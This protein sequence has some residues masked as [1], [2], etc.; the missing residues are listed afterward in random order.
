MAVF[1][2]GATGRKADLSFPKC[3]LAL[4]RTFGEV[5]CRGT[6]LPALLNTA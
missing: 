4:R 2:L 3:L 5:V 1:S 6:N